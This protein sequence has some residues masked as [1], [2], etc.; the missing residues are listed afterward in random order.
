MCASPAETAST[1]RPVP[2]FT[3]A[4]ASPISLEASPMSACEPIPN[5]P[6]APLPKHFTAAVFNNTH[7][8]A[9]PA[10][11]ATALTLVPKLIGNN[12][13]PISFTS[14]PRSFV[15]PVPKRPF[16]PE[17]QHFTVALS[18]N[19]HVCRS[20]ADIA[21]AVR[22]VPKSIAGVAATVEPVLS[23]MLSMFP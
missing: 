22:P 19:A 10:V 1:V 13:S 6:S 21:T 11:I 5:F 7:V 15:S 20:P 4:S 18:S 2:R 3:V 8:C 14:T 9:P 17:P 16:P 23:P 12:A